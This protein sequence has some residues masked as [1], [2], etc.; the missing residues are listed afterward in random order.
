MASYT[1][2]SSEFWKILSKD[3]NLGA[4]DENIVLCHSRDGKPK[5]YTIKKLEKQLRHLL[6]CQIVL[7]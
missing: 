7:L 3:E 1:I 5:E 6:L 2:S 4:I